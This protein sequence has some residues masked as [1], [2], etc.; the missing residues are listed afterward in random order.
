MSFIKDIIE[1]A[2]ENIILRRDTHIDQLADKLKEERV[3]KVIEPILAGVE[4]PEQIPV[5]DISYVEDLGLIQTKGQLNIAN[6]IYQE[7]IPRELTYSTQLTITHKTAWYIDSENGQLI[8]N[9]LLLAFQNF[10]REHSKHWVEQFD[11]KEA[12]QQLLLQAFLQR[13]INSGGRIE[14]EYGLGRMRTYLL[15]IWPIN[16]SNNTLQKIVLELKILHK[17]LE[18]T[19]AKGLKQTSLYIDRCNENEGHL[20]IFNCDTKK[21]WDDKI[22]HKK[23][24]FNN[25]TITIWGM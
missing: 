15:I 14:R 4:K 22:F 18:Q 10:F 5:D 16:D 6:R 24:F 19:I 2:K 17:S 25:K 21:S 13:I 11:Y 12:G 9:K 7:I 23:E 20:I 1:K 8:V 3:R